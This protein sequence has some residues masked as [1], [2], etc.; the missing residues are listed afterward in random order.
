MSIDFKKIAYE[1]TETNQPEQQIIQLNTARRHAIRINS[2]E[3]KKNEYEGSS[4][5]K[6]RELIRVPVDSIALFCTEF[7][8]SHFP[9]NKYITYI[10]TINGVD[11]EIEPI[12]SHRSGKKIIRHSDLDA[13]Q[14]YA[15]YVN[16]S[17]KSAILT[18][19]IRSEGTTESPL[20]SNIKILYGR[21]VDDNG[22]I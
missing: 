10:M 7:V 8:P 20:L 21:G 15:I 22:D 6:S 14:P 17:I 19:V 18:I 13:D 5:M 1:K 2:I 12:N 4:T 3:A 16:E 11:Y 9:K